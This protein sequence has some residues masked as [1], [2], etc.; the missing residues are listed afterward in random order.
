MRLHYVGICIGVYVRGLAFGGK[1]VSS[2]SKWELINKLSVVLP[3]IPCCTWIY[4]PVPTHPVS[5]WPLSRPNRLAVTSWSGH[6]IRHCGLSFLTNV[7]LISD[8]HS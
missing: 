8:L 6:D 3:N 2:P 5:C 4:M 7:A 1:D